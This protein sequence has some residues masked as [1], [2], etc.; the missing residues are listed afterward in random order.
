MDA[1][2]KKPAIDLAVVLGGGKGGKSAPPSM[3]NEPD[4]DDMGGKPEGDEDE[5]M[6]AGFSQAAEEVFDPERSPEER[7][8]ALYRAIKACTEGY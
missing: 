2:K 3:H 6:P 4:A 1:A 8:A 7:T 5:A